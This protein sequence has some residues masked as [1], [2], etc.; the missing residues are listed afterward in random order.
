[1]TIAGGLLWG[2]AILFIGLIHLAQPTYGVNFL[3]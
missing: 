3:D 1:M 2:A